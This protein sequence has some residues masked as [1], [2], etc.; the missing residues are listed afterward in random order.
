MSAVLRTR[1]KIADLTAWTALDAGRRLL[2][3]GFS[4]SRLVR[5]E[6]VLFE[7][8]RGFAADAFEKPLLHAIEKS[9]FFVNPNKEQFRFLS[10][11]NRGE[12]LEPLSGAWGILTRPREG[13]E[14]AGLLERL[15][16]EHPME[17]LGAIRK[18]RIW[19]LWTK[20]PGGDAA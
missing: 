14:D 10:S 1:L 2:P 6:L 7:P 5:E 15:L 9:N 20:G 17:G 11:S 18:A 12:A 19:W 16:R 3:H 13:T 4:L 8:A